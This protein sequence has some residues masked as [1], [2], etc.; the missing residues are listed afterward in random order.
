MNWFSDRVRVQWTE[1]WARCHQLQAS[2]KSRVAVKTLK[3]Q[4]L[5]YSQAPTLVNLSV[6][7]QKLT[8]PGAWLK[9][10][11]LKWG[12]TDQFPPK[13]QNV[14]EFDVPQN[15]RISHQ[16]LQIESEDKNVKAEILSIHCKN[17]YFSGFF[18]YLQWSTNEKWH[19]KNW[20]KWRLTKVRQ[21][22]FS[23]DAVPVLVLA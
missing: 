6:P 10:A 17:K 16:M 1:E 13:I 22:L 21:G 20:L 3:R 11:W 18:S 9:R 19:L 14:C 2:E 8:K 12:H 15:L 5:D 23:Y 4:S 7:C